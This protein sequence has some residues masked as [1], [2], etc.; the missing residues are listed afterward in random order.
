APDG[1]A[2]EDTSRLWPQLERLRCMLALRKSGM[3]QFEDKIEMAVQNIFE[4]YLDPAPAGMW[5]DRIDS[6]GKIVSN[7]IPQS[8]FYH[9]VACF[10]DYLDALGEKEATLA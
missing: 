5:E 7:E 1:T 8:S 10:T 3:A 4:A 6:V 9:I 2:I